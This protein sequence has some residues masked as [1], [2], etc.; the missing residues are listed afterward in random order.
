MSFHIYMSS[1]FVVFSWIHFNL[2]FNFH[3]PL[4]ML[5]YSFFSFEL[6]SYTPDW[7]GILYVAQVGLLC[8]GVIGMSHYTIFKNTDL[9]SL[10]KSITSQIYQIQNLTKVHQMIH[11]LGPGGIFHHI[12]LISSVQFILASLLPFHA[13]QIHVPW[14][15][16]LS[17]IYSSF[18]KST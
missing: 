18:W 5:I 16:Y 17:L 8:A 12:S 13:N 6:G 7:T 1:D 10:W 3:P 9:N 15:L 11:D 2:Y 4:G 14:P